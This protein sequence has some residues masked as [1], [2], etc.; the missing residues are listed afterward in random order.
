MTGQVERATTAAAAAVDFEFV[1]VQARRAAEPDVATLTAREMFARMAVD[2]RALADLFVRALT[3]LDTDRPILVTALQTAAK[4][5]Y[6]L[7]AY[8]DAYDIY[9]GRLEQGQTTPPIPEG[10]PLATD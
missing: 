5:H 8:H 1:I 10:T 3:T 4:H 2:E 9:A 7:A 6:D